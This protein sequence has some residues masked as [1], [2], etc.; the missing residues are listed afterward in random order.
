MKSNKRNMA[1][2][3]LTALIWGMGFVAQSAGGDAI[4]AFSFNSIRMLVGAAALLPV[5]KLLD[6]TGLNKKKPQTQR[7]KK[8]TL[9][10]GVFC[11]VI[12]T[13]AS[14]F[15]QQGITMGTSAG[16]AGFI[17]ACYIVFVP[18][19]GIFVGK[20]INIKIIAGV[21][22]TVIGLYMLCM[23]GETGIQKSDLV[24]L[25]CSVC[26]AVHI[27]VIDRFSPKADGVRMSCIQFLVCGLLTALPMII[28]EIVPLGIGV[29][30][31]Y[32]NSIEAWVSI[33][34][35]GILSCGV[36]YTLQ[37]VGQVGVEP[38]LAS[39]LLSLESVFSV[40][41]GRILLH[42]YLGIKEIMG[43][44]LIFVAIILAQLPDKK[45]A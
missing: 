8:N 32:F 15:Q 6:K 13:V 11:G 12:L 10:G 7:D 3:V 38:T 43:C 44:A 23:N 24:V 41:S 5:I 17:T 18:I 39:M 28:F 19:I 40:I 29:W 22:L 27:M 26:Y 33:L 36:A 31:S 25:M 20:K 37:I 35:A 9:I 30:R 2:L 34:Y 14:N 4:G 16:K 42:Q 45:K 1:L 21:G